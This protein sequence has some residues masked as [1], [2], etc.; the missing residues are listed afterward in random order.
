M[1]GVSPMVSDTSL[2]P[3]SRPNKLYVGRTRKGVVLRSVSDAVSE[4]SS[5]LSITSNAARTALE[6]GEVGASA[7]AGWLTS[8]AARR[9][10]DAWEEGEAGACQGPCSILRLAASWWYR[11]CA[12]CQ[13]RRGR[14]FVGEFTRGAYQSGHPQDPAAQCLRDV[15][16]EDGETWDERR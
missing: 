3:K 14:E 9:M 5:S 12:H 8:K 6:K 15:A 2:A 4:S 11:Q 1:I 16:Q 13:G 7:S 10:L